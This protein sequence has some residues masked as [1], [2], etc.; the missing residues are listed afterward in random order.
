MLPDSI[1]DQAALLWL[2]ARQQTLPKC[3][4]RLGEVYSRG[5]SQ[6]DGRQLA[7]ATAPQPLSHGQGNVRLRSR[8]IFLPVVF[9]PPLHALVVVRKGWVPVTDVELVG[10]P[11]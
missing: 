6:A 9:V 5:G 8:T 1:E 11:R 3:R 2:Q 4:R 7:E 10:D